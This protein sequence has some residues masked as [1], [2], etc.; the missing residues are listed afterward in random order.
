MA[1]K[2]LGPDHPDVAWS[3]HNFAAAHESTG[4]YEDARALRE[5]P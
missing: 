3:L 5:R 2:T 4:S 1:E